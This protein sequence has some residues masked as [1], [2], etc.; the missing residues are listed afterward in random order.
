MSRKLII[1]E[2]AGGYFHIKDNGSLIDNAVFKLG[3]EFSLNGFKS[4]ANMDDNNL[5]IVSKNGKFVVE[6]NYLLTDNFLIMVILSLIEN[7]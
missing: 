5:T 4:I 6:T 1:E 3:E 2:A 7:C